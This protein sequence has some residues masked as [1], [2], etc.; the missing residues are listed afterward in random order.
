MARLRPHLRP[1]LDLA[2]LPRRDG[3]QAHRLPIL[4]H[5]Q[6]AGLFAE[7]PFVRALRYVQPPPR[8]SRLARLGEPTAW[9]SV[10]LASLF[11]LTFALTC[12]GLDRLARAVWPDADPSV[13]IVA[14]VLILIAKAGNIGT[15]HLFEAML[16][17]RLIGLQR[18]AGLRWPRLS[19]IPGEVGGPPRF[20]SAW[21][22]GIHPSVGLQLTMMLGAGWIGWAFCSTS[23]RG[24]GG[25]HAPR[26][27]G[28]RIGG[29]LPAPLEHE[30]K[31]RSSSRGC[32]P[33]TSGS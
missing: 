5:Q 27:G 28:A 32:P 22:V 31:G 33:R 21:P 7:D 30:A 1:V 8:L 15:N 16:L 9:A 6:N 26:P 17:D 18:W 24:H 20:S 19:T 14:V 2:G 25:S 29:R 13:G 3:D 10:G 11:A 4:L 12:L 23:D